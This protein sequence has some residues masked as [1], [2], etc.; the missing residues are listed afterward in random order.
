MA[1]RYIL[2]TLGISW[3]AAGAFAMSG[4]ALGSGTGTLFAVAYMFIPLL[5][6]YTRTPKG[7]FRRTIGWKWTWNRWVVVAWTT[8]MVLVALIIGVTL[9]MPDVTFDSTMEGMIA[10][11]GSMLTAQELETMRAQL[12][13][14]P[15]HPAVLAF[16]QALLA[17]ITINAIAA[18]GEEA[19]WRGYLHDKF[20]AL[21]FWREAM[22]IGFVWGLWHAPLIAM[23]HNYPQHPYIGIAMMVVLGM[24]L[25]PFMVLVRIKSGTVFAPTIF[26]GTMNATAAIPLMLIAGGSDLIVGWTGLAG[27]IV[28]GLLNGALYLAMRQRLITLP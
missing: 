10:R 3:A 28:L 8:P 23:G 11:Y 26:H 24:L 17:G 20:G 4:V 5:V 2:I 27:F 22:L 7:D 18:F 15:I 1:W 19:G 21:G 25:T 12:D 14:M 13:A 16:A 9:L 6:A